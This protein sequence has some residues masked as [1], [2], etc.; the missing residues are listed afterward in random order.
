MEN[1]AER[2]TESATAEPGS[3]DTRPQISRQDVVGGAGEVEIGCK[4]G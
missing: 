2:S 1:E 4:G 3:A